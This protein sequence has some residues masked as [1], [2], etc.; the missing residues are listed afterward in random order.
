MWRT[1]QQRMFFL[2]PHNFT[3]VSDNAGG[4]IISLDR[5]GHRTTPGHHHTTPVTK[6]QPVEKPQEQGPRGDPV[7][8]RK[9]HFRTYEDTTNSLLKRHILS[10][11]PVV[12]IEVFD[13]I[14][15]RKVKPTNYVT[16]RWVPTI[17]TDKQDNFL[18]AKAR[19]ELRAFQDKQKDH[20]QTDP[21]FHKTR[22][23]EE[24]PDGSQQRLGSFSH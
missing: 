19:W 13:L 4:D 20:Q 3:S 7:H 2:R 6:W 23:S 21:C 16:G 10:T 9:H 1:H 12:D 24:L 5:Y 15:K 14:D 22:I 17:K 11:H 8:E 18:S